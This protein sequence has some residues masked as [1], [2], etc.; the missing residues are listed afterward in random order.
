MKKN[1]KVDSV[2]KVY[3]G[4]AVRFYTPHSSKKSIAEICS[5]VK[6]I[7][8]SLHINKLINDARKRI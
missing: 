6:P 5:S 2:F 4:T 1:K 8:K 7:P 3:N